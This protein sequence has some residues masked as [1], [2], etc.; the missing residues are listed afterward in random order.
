M[1]DTVHY[2]NQKNETFSVDNN[3]AKHRI[4]R[5]YEGLVVD[6]ILDHKHPQYSLQ[7]GSGGYNV[8]TIK[9]RIFDVQ[10]GV[11]DDFLQYADPI[12]ST[13]NQYPLKGEV[14]ELIKIR[15][16][17]YY[18][19][20]V[21]I[22]RRIQENA[23]LKLNEALR[24]RGSNTQARLVS[25]GDEQTI[26]SHK[27]GT[28]FRPDSRV[29]Q[30]KHFEGDTLHQG[31]MGNTLRF[32]S[33]RMDP[34]SDGLAPNILLRAGQAKGIEEDPNRRSF[35]SVFSLI[36]EDLN[37][38]VSSM[39]MVSDQ[40]LP[41]KPSTIDAG[42]FYR[43]IHNPPTKFDG[44]SITLNSDRI[45]L[46]SKN[47]HIMMFSNEEIYLN[48][49]KRTSIDTD[50][51]I[52]LTAKLNIELKAS[53]Y[54]ENTA[55]KD[56]F[57]RT[58]RDTSIISNRHSSIISEKIFIGNEEDYSE[59]IVAGTT[60]SK[61]LARLIQ[62]LMG[63]GSPSEPSPSISP[64]PSTITH[65]VLGGVVPVQLSPG[66]VAGLTTLYR[67]LVP[68]NP[69]AKQGNVPFSG[70]VF[71]SQD[72]YTSITNDNPNSYVELNEYV[73]GEVE[74]IENNEW[75]LSNKSYYR[76]V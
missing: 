23:M 36:L 20:K 61:F 8:G 66:I 52:F 15:G 75:N 24:S 62:V 63:T 22:S 26:T 49:F 74:D 12:D 51:N 27:F 44:G 18:K 39:W 6:V 21:Y 48:S 32:G 11:G 50:E 41:F 28:Y 2:S 37:E 17:F 53:E 47:T 30:L 29:R 76:V 71:N 45:V 42:S 55:D 34:R 57:V 38:D 67:E 5:I 43:S 72:N 56:F 10:Q 54:I 4:D 33:S 9:V 14:V 46:N 73:E 3:T 40:H 25:S 19:P 64:G 69:G 65:G 31:R 68:S 60:L 16:N 70:A 1:S 58:G 13:Y 7:R 59:P 35:N